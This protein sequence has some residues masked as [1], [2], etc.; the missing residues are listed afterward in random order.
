MLIARVEFKEGRA[1]RRFSLYINEPIQVVA[2]AAST[3]LMRSL[4]IIAAHAVL[5]LGM[6]DPRLDGGTT[7]HLTPDRFRDRRT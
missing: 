1:H 3:A 6:T 2:G 7:L 4:E 5:V